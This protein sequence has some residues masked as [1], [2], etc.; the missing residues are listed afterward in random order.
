VSDDVASPTETGETVEES[1]GIYDRW[2]NVKES[3]LTVAILTLVGVFLAPAIL[4]EIPPMLGVP[5]SLTWYNG[6]VALTLIW[7]I[8]A[9]GYDILLGF[10]GLLSFGHAMFWGVG[11]YAVG[12]ISAEFV[13]NPLVLILLGTTFAVLLAWIIGWISL[14]RGGI[15]FAILTLA[16]GQMMYYIFL[17]PLGW[18]TGGENGFNGVDVGA[19]LGVIDLGASVPVIPDVFAASWGYVLIALFTVLAVVVG[20]RILNSPYGAVLQAI[21][22]NEQRTEFVGLNVWRYKLMGFIISGAFAGVAGSLYVIQESY[23][24]IENTLNWVVSGDVVVITVLGGAGSLFGP[25]FGAGL[26]M[27]V[28]NIVVGIPIIG[29]FWHMILGLVF[30]AV[31]VVMPEGIWGGI[32]WI[33]KLVGGLLGGDGQ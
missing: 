22:E 7:G 10:T 6:L 1:P 16:F 18:L 12:I 29:E 11:A 4:V 8:F 5:S 28:A 32:S 13:Q 25:L 33:R 31:V 17:S 20:Y 3:E 19:L 26:Y 15:Y 21:R 30:I 27:Y 2:L 9:I 23:V 14:R 24:P